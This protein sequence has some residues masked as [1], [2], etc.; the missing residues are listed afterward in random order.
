MVILFPNGKEYCIN[1]INNDLIISQL[2]LAKYGNPDLICVNMHW[3][4]EYQTHQNQEQIDLAN[5]LFENGVDIILGSHP[6]VLEPM[7]KRTI[8]MPDGKNKD[9]FVIYSLGN[10]M[11]GQVKE[12]TRTSIILNLKITKNGKTN[13]ITIDD[14][15]YIPIYTYTYPNYQ[16]Y[17]ILDIEKTLFNYNSGNTNISNTTYELLNNELE[18]THNLLN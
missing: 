12:N 6:H 4:E 1:L 17:K 13:D 9:V 3:G 2:E 8:T 7:E 18:K 14:I 5:L 15:S 11:S 16:N 10:F